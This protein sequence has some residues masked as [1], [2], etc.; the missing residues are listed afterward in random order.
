M[1]PPTVEI[2]YTKRSNGILSLVVMSG[3]SRVRAVG[4]INW[5]LR[6]TCHAERSVENSNPSD[7]I[8]TGELSTVQPPSKCF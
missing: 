2:F 5:T 4:V 1:P 8:S 3:V 7:G 6:H